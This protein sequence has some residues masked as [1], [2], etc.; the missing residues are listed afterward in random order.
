VLGRIDAK[1]A[2]YAAEMFFSNATR[3]P[4][5]ADMMTIGDMP[6]DLLPWR[7]G[8]WMLSNPERIAGRWVV[9]ALSYSFGLGDDEYAYRQVDIVVRT[10]GG[11]LTATPK[12]IGPLVPVETIDDAHAFAELATGRDLPELPA[13]PAGTRLA[14][15]YGLNAYRWAGSM[16]ASIAMMDPSRRGRSGGRDMTFAFGEGIDFSLGCG[17]AVDPD[18]VDV[19]GIPAMIDKSGSTRQVVWPATPE[20]PTGSFS[21][22][23]NMSRK[24]L[25]ELAEEVATP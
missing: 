23:G 17:G 6:G 18:P 12:A 21:V 15:D 4:R 20:E 11:R 25:L 2:K 24:E 10:N 3:R 22:H 14:R 7:Y 9:P 8:G 5:R 1:E 16:T 13:L 19:A